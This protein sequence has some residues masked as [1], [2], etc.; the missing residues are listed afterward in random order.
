MAALLPPLAS[1]IRSLPN[2]E[3]RWLTEHYPNSPTSPRQCITCKGAGT[4]RWWNFYDGSDFDLVRTIESRGGPFAPDD[5]ECECAN[6]WLLHRYLLSRGIGTSYQRLGWHDLEADSSALG[7]IL[8]WVAYA[9]WNIDNGVGLI[10]S[11]ANGT[12]KTLM[13]VLLL[14]YLL[15]EGHHGY[16]IGAEEAVTLFKDSWRDPDEKR[17]LDRFVRHTQVLV[18]DDL[19]KEL[20]V[21]GDGS[22]ASSSL[23]TAAF[24]SALRDR[25]ANSLPTIITTNLSWSDIT[26]TYSSSILGLFTERSIFIEVGGANFRL[27]TGNRLADEMRLGLTRPVVVG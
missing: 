22:Q 2:D 21:R 18:L 9:E 7:D 16:L 5:Y 26:D 3:D 11:G 12:G 10:L 6:Q 17:R 20:R 23:T 15:A 27:R 25:V 24:D 4:F 14:K 8:T 1:G 19:G 13:A